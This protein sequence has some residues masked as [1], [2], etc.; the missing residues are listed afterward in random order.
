MKT[1]GQCGEEIFTR[2]CMKCEWLTPSKRDIRAARQRNAKHE[3]LVSFGLER[4]PQKQ[5]G[6]RYE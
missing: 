2:M 4:V 1:C 5:G 3:T 6:F